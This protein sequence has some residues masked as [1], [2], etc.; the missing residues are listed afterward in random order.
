MGENARTGAVHLLRDNKRVEVPI[1]DEAIQ[2]AIE[3]VEWAVDR[4]INRDYPMRP[5]TN[6]CADCDF[7]LLC[8]QRS[9]NFQ[10]SEVPPAIHVPGSV[11][12]VPIEIKSFS[13][14]ED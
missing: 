6:K 9:E 3:N 2:A 10:T 7:N 11:S 5:H 4:I 13:Q 1:I 12:D 14:F 8:S